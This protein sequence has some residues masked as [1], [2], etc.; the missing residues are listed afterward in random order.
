MMGTR[1]GAVDPGILTFLMR[2]DGVSARQL[3]NLLNSQSDSSRPVQK[4]E[5]FEKCNRTFIEG[6]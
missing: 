5:R 3:D 2:Q 6:E 4:A 1:S